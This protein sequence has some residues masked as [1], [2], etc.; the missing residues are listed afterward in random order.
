MPPRLAISDFGQIMFDL[1]HEGLI[2]SLTNHIPDGWAVHEREL[3]LNL[4]HKDGRFFL[5]NSSPTEVSAIGLRYTTLPSGSTLVVSLRINY[6]ESIDGVPIPF[7]HQGA[8]ILAAPMTVTIYEP[9]GIYA[10][11]SSY[12]SCIE[13]LLEPLRRTGWTLAKYAPHAASSYGG[14]LQT[15]VQKKNN[16]QFNAMLKYAERYCCGGAVQLLKDRSENIHNDKTIGTG[17]LLD[18]PHWCGPAY[19]SQYLFGMY[20][21]KNCV[22]ISLVELCYV[23]FGKPLRYEDFEVDNPNLIL[24]RKYDKL[25]N[26][27]I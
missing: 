3:N 5:G 25:L 16:A 24:L 14:G 9:Y 22:T 2:P 20:T 4:H 23:A 10:K 11:K 7:N 15:I 21:S 1:A 6:G 8:I 17:E 27:N 13:E 26:G 18:N 12:F 19:N